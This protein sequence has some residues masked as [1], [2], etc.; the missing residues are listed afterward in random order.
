M[1][2]VAERINSSRKAINQA[3]KDKDADFIRSEAKTQAEAGAH[4]IDVNAGS[5]VEQEAEYLC[6]LV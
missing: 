4:Y 5:F 6:W 3:I 2:I 1:L